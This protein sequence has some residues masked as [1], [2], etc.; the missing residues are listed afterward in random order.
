MIA[1]IRSAIGKSFSA[2]I[3]TLVV[4]NV[5]VTSIVIGFV[6]MRNTES[7][8]TSKISEKFPSILVN[9][10][11]KVD[12]WYAKRS[13]DIAILSGST[14]F[15]E[16]LQK[17]LKSLSEA[18]KQKATVEIGKY[19]S[20]VKEKFLVYEELAVLDED[21][22]IIAKTSDDILEDADLLQSLM[23]EEEGRTVASQA[24]LSPDRSK[25]HQWLLVP[26][27]IADEFHAT[28]CARLALVE[29][30]KLLSEVV[31]G[32]GGDLFLLDFRGRFVTQPRMASSNMLGV[33]AMEV[34]TRQERPVSVDRYANYAS[35][36]VLGSKVLLPDL[37]WWLVCEED[38]KAAMSPVLTTRHRIILADLIILAIFVLAALRI[39]RPIL[40]PIQ[41]LAD[42][43]KKIKDGMVGVKIMATSDD[44]LGLM[45]QTFNEMA[46][47]IGMAR[48]KL[49]AK[50]KELNA[51]NEELQVLNEKLEELSITDGLTGLYN[52]RHFW[53]L[54]NNEMS[55]VDR[56]GGQLAL[57]LIDIDNFKR[58]ND[59]FGHAV[60]D[61]LLH[62][63]GDVLRDSVRDTDILSRYGGEEFAVLL[64][65]TDQEGVIAVAEK[66]RAA[67]EKMVFKV[68]ETDITLSMTVSLGVSIYQGNKRE[69]FNA[70]DQALYLSKHKGK[71]CVSFA[72]CT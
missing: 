65:E 16:N 1:R 43:A 45:I 68:P 19:F 58:V 7:F 33:K 48:V 67:V 34:P 29:L 64:P 57:V 55:R 41:S 49:Q 40:R 18:D 22:E 6:T 66:I 63:L 54:L 72:E 2:K 20:Y 53:N 26:I 5:V 8:L 12:L 21:G 9:T 56:S 35:R 32:K 60:G 47:E 3:I 28:I 17:R 51:R 71:N 24:V 62:T 44:E 42:G 36:K 37:G 39:V 61:V 31:L 59:R 10:R 23:Q 46:K 69:F 52:H 11:G 15:S 38:Y 30:T 50:N 14:A 4:V 27:Q 70:V 13:L 25:I